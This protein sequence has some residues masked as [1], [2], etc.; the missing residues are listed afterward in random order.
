MGEIVWDTGATK[1]ADGTPVQYE[2][3]TLFVPEN[4]AVANSRLIE[5]HPKILPRLIAFLKT[6]DTRDFPTSVSMPDPTFQKPSFPPV[7]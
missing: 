4:R 3:G 2:L 6:G 5:Q 1:T 7:Q